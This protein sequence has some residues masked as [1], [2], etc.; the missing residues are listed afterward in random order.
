MSYFDET[1]HDIS[2]F[3]K[4]YRNQRLLTVERQKSFGPFQV[5]QWLWAIVNKFD[6]RFILTLRNSIGFSGWDKQPTFEFWMLLTCFFFHPQTNFSGRKRWPPTKTW[7]QFQTW[8]Y[9][10][11]G[12]QNECAFFCLVS[13][14]QMWGHTSGGGGGLIGVA[15]QIYDRWN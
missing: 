2:A 13:K 4:D 10:C 9:F 14:C 12:S 7:Q 3:M 1:Y 11:L 5:K 6:N 8:I 15:V